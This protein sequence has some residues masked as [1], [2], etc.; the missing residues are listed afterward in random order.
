MSPDLGDLP[1]IIISG[2]YQETIKVHSMTLANG[3]SSLH[4]I[5]YV[6]KAYSI[7]HPS[8]YPRS[9]LQA[10]IFFSSSAPRGL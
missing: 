9:Q 1:P 3:S 7:P 2:I 8:R 6:L 5:L 4:L 10:E